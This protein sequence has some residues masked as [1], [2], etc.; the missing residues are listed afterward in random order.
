MAS[1]GR[2]GVHHA[3][4]TSIGR[5]SAGVKPFLSLFFGTCWGANHLQVWQQ[6]QPATLPWRDGGHTADP[7]TSA[8]KT[9]AEQASQR[10]AKLA[11]EL[12]KSRLQKEKNRSGD[13]LPGTASAIDKSVAQRQAKAPA[14]PHRPNQKQHEQQPGDFKAQAAGEPGKKKPAKTQ[15]SDKASADSG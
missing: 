5:L 11:S 7:R 15:R 12:E 6:L 4:T 3:Q 9:Q 1:V 10:D 8:Q 14:K 2:I 13:G